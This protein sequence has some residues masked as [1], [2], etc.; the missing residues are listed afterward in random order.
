MKRTSIEKL[1]IPSFLIELLSSFTLLTLFY[2]SLAVIFFLF[3]YYSRWT[4]R[5]ADR[6]VQ[7]IEKG[8]H[9]AKALT[10]MYQAKHL[11][12][13]KAQTDTY[14]DPDKLM[15]WLAQKDPSIIQI[16][17]QYITSHPSVPARIKLLLT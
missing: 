4:E 8:Y 6:T 9:L 17:K 7:N 12:K 10:K 3:L 15:N 16:L 5:R 2:L 13:L 1:I 14:N 11:E